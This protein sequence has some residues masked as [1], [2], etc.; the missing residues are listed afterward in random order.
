MNELTETVASEAIFT[1]QFNTRD[2]VR[3]TIRNARVDEKS[4]QEAVRQVV[5]FHRYKTPR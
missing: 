2:A 3:Y 4:A 1:L 5:V